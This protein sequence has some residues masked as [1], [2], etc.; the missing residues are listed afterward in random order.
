MARYAAER[1]GKQ[2]PES[3]QLFVLTV[4]VRFAAL[5]NIEMKLHVP[6]S[7]ARSRIVG[8]VFRQPQEVKLR[9]CR[10]Q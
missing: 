8:Q 10:E 6:I 3:E 2:A 7:D 4:K 9:D 1:L 5:E